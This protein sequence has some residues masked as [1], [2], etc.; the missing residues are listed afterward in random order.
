M[1]PQRSSGRTEGGKVEGGGGNN[2]SL[3]PWGLSSSFLL[4]FME[5]ESGLCMR[6]RRFRAAR[7]SFYCGQR[8]TKERG[9]EE[10]GRKVK[11]NGKRKKMSFEFY[12]GE[13]YNPQTNST[14]F[15]LRET[16]GLLRLYC[17]VYISHSQFLFSFR[18]SYLC[19]IGRLSLQDEK[20]WL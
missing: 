6:R 5:Q 20:G 15:T 14:W 13:I 9:D 4:F 3:L 12:N 1:R 11:R 19:R 18:R 2:D 10:T 7:S 8:N 17:T 16:C